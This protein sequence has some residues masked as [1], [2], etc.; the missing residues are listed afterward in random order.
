MCF[1]N[2]RT[3]DVCVY[4]DDLQYKIAE[5]HYIPVMEE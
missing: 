5:C 4:S 2:N 1:D 3:V